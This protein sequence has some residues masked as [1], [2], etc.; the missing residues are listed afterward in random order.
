MFVRC[1]D[2]AG[3][4]SCTISHP[5]IRFTFLTFRGTTWLSDRKINKMP[6]LFLYTTWLEAIELQPCL[7]LF[8]FVLWICFLHFRPLCA[9][10]LIY[11][12]SIVLSAMTVDQIDSL[13][14]AMSVR[15]MRPFS[16]LI[17]STSLPYSFYGRQYYYYHSLSIALT[18][19]R[20]HEQQKKNCCRIEYFNRDTREPFC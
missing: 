12:F 1:F 16:H 11:T 3:S 20:C 19:L 14:T 5:F 10:L 15:W 6:T 7:L 9:F 13:V 4:C 17:K 2:M 8:F 18:P